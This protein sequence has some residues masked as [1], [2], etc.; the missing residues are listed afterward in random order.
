MN[1]KKFLKLCFYKA[2]YSF[3]FIIY[4]KI[5]TSNIDLTNIKIK[6]I[7]YIDKIDFKKF[8]YKIAIIKNGRAFTNY[9]ENLAVISRKLFLKIFLFNKLMVI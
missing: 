1:F 3:F 2:I 7:D 8:N 4:G 6:K 5:E 9:V